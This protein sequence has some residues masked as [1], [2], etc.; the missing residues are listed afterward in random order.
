MSKPSF[1]EVEKLLRQAILPFYE[2]IRDISVPI[3]PR[4]LENDAEHSWSL[5]LLACALAPEID[6]K[7]D[8][9]KVCMFAVVHDLVEIYAGDTSVWSDEE[10]LLSKAKRE[11]AAIEE[12]IVNFSAFPWVSQTVESYERKDTAEA[13]YV[14]AL[15]KF[16]NLLIIYADKNLHNIENYKTTK[17]MFDRQLIPHRQKAHSHPAVGEYYEQLRAA[18]DAHPEYFYQGEIPDG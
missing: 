14:Y 11:E 6:S 5:A 2:I 13:Q 17:E 4:R 1:E 10:K 12:I 8:V 9:G 18:F 16:L 3:K 7:L 15:D